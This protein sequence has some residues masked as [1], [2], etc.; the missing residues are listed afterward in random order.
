MKNWWYYHKW[1]VICGLILLGILIDLAGNGLGLWT[2]KPDLQIAYVGDT[3]LPEDTAAALE[4]ALASL[5][6]DFNGDG[7]VL[8]QL[9]QYVRP[10]QSQD[11]DA[12]YYRMTSEISLIGDISDCDS[13]LFLTDD[14]ERLQREFHILACPDGSCPKDS[15]YSVEGKALPWK[16]C[17]SLAS[18][19]L[20][21]YTEYFLGQELSGDSQELLS[22]LFLGRRCFYNSD[23]TKYPEQCAEFWE[24][25]ALDH[26]EI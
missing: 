24:S 16:D 8:V 25:I 11:E 12:A 2:E 10:P 15:D 3:A 6:T 4:Q 7:R 22:H 9:N 17:L 26:R 19:D 5:L 13:Y 23:R 1:Y 20:D 21:G 18:L 14:P